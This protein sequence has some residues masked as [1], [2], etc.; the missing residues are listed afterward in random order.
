[1][2]IFLLRV[3]LLLTTSGLP[4]SAHEAAGRAGHKEGDEA[5]AVETDF[6]AGPHG[7]LHGGIGLLQPL[8]GDYQAGLTLHLVREE[9]GG[10]WFPSLGAEVARHFDNGVELEAFSFGYFPVERQFAWALG[11][12]AMKAFE[13][14]GGWIISPFIGPTFA[15]VRAM[16]EVTDETVDV[17]HTMLLGGVLL[18]RGSVELGVFGSH[19]WFSRDTRGLETHV[20][21]EEMTHLAAYENNDGFASDSVGG[22]LNWA[23]TKRFDVAVRYAAIFFPGESARHSITILPSV[24]IAEGVKISAGVQFLRGAGFDRT[25]FASGFSWEF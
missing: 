14:R 15:R 11:A 7:Y 10:S 6:F 21:L 24:A 20:D 1:M 12:R 9:S 8:G 17:S 23:V 13:V 5:S 18:T 19:S 3:A 4:L 22:E 2:K 25:L 16:D